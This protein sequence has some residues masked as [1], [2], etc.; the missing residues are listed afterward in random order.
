MGYLPYDELVKL[1]DAIADSYRRRGEFVVREMFGGDHPVKVVTYTNPQLFSMVT[2]R[3]PNGSEGWTRI[4]I[5]GGGA[6]GAPATPDLLQHL[7]QR[8]AEFDWG[9]PFGAFYRDNT[10]TYGTRLRFPSSLVSAD[11][12]RD[13]A[14]FVMEMINVMGRTARML[15]T[16]GIARFG[17]AL[18]DGSGP[19]HDSSFL[20][21]VMGPAPKDMNID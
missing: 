10:L 6:I 20:A 7:L 2:C 1:L 9:D 12:P 18:L 21:A 3:R 13:G 16:E 11:D 14:Q 4:T 19:R 5:A 15:A 17:G 8:G